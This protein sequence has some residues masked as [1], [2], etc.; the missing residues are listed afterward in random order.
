MGLLIHRAKMV[1]QFDQGSWWYVVLPDLG[2]QMK[3]PSST[4]AWST[5]TKAKELSIPCPLLTVACNP[6]WTERLSRTSG[7]LLAQKC[8]EII[9][10]KADYPLS[11][12]SGTVCPGNLQH[13]SA[14]VKTTKSLSDVRSGFPALS[15]QGN[16]FI[17]LPI[18]NTAFNLLNQGT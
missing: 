4:G 7:R 17:A 6:V 15:R 1:A 10:D 13:G 14:W 11:K 8:S 18:L 12:I 16:E 2:L 9:V 5:P 3:S